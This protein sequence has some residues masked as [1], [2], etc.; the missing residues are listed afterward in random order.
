MSESKQSISEE[1]VQIVNNPDSTES[2]SQEE[3]KIET[4]EVLYSGQDT[5]EMNFLEKNDTDLFVLTVDGTPQCYTQTLEHA[6]QRL[7]DFARMRQFSDYHYNS[8]IR[9]GNGGNDI[10]VVGYH[11]F[12]LVSYERVRCHLSVRRIQRIDFPVN[13]ESE[14]NVDKIMYN[15]FFK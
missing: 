10:Y 2:E 1:E 15:L 7:W 11:K 8:Y 3:T 4:S 14:T 5:D 12:Y 6:R 9:E 13:K